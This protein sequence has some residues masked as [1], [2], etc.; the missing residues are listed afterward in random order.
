LNSG[1]HDMVVPFQSTQAWIKYMNYSIIDDWRPW[2]IDGQVAGY[3]YLN[4]TSLDFHSNWIRLYNCHE[5]L[6]YL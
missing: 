6:I 4:F 1:D 2:T 5:I 3:D